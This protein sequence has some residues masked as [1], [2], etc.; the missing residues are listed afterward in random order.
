MKIDGEKQAEI[1]VW[2]NL[3]R[4]QEYRLPNPR[5]VVLLITI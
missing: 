4:S 2:F 5:G 3:E 1:K